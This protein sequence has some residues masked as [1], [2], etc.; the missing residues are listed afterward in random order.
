[1]KNKIII[2]ISI[3]TSLLILILGLNYSDRFNNFIFSNFVNT[4][5]PLISKVP[6]TIDT[7]LNITAPKIQ[8]S[9]KTLDAESLNL[10]PQ[11]KI[12]SLQNNDYWKDPRGLFPIFAYNIPDSTKNY[13]KS[14][15]IIENGGINIIINGNFGWMPDPIKMKN[16]FK[17]LENSQLKWIAII[18]NECKDDFIYR[19]SNDEI[20]SN[21]RP[22]LEMFNDN[23]VYGW[24]IWDEP[25][26]N[27]KLC[28]LF[29]LE[30]NNDNEDISRMVTQIRSD[31]VFNH[32]LDFVNLFPT[33]WD[34]T[35]DSVSYSKY[36]DA[37]ISSQ[38]YK[39]KVLCID[40]Y[41][42]L[43]S[44]I[45]GFRKDYYLNLDIICK[46]S[47]E[48]NIPFWIVILSSGHLDYK[49]PSFYEISLQVYSALA[50]GAKGIGYYLYS[51][52]WQEVGY[53]SWILENFVD[54][55]NI[56]DS[57]HGALYVPVKQLNKQ[58]QTL[59][60]TL[61]NL[62]S[63]EIIHSSDFPNNQMKISNSFIVNGKKKSFI[64][65]IVNAN[66]INLDPKVLVGILKKRIISD[67][68]D[69][70]LLVVNKDVTMTVNVRIIFQKSPNIFKY[71]KNDGTRLFIAKNDTLNTCILPGSGELFYV[72]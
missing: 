29:N 24:Y 70:Y 51:K 71:N 44:E 39:P 61:L 67:E 20:N 50:Y 31:S 68:N 22:F 8:K 47:I 40:N 9:D 59:G 4:Y 7:Q 49:N 13:S 30:P 65:S 14:L 55:D 64:K 35:P 27:R 32:K 16:E 62:E 66:D 43:K 1:M 38:K 52:S 2:F 5:D 23:F 36:I 19:N 42:L 10:T 33:Y 25:G 21:I 56:A 41:P 15:K 46:K 11:I 63:R 6:K 53:K 26:G 69:F 54:N 58:I 17:K 72:E 34:G 28:S 18:E 45:E 57:L 60:K 37:F 48:Y 3:L 12:N